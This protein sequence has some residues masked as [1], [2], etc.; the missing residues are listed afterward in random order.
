MICPFLSATRHGI[1]DPRTRFR[2]NLKARPPGPVKGERMRKPKKFFW[3]GPR[4]RRGLSRLSPEKIFRR[5][6]TGPGGCATLSRGN[7]PGSQ[8]RGGWPATGPI[9]APGSVLIPTPR[10]PAICP[11][12]PLTS[13]ISF[14]LRRG[15]T[16]KSLTNVAT[17]CY[18][19]PDNKKTVPPLEFRPL[20]K[21]ESR[22]DRYLSHAVTFTV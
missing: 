11:I 18:T 9:D 14:R 15:L 19:A 3:T 17:L 10:R 22:P 8:F 2:G 4:F 12:K 20:H 5:P 13:P 7:R 1:R 16:K 6:L 21:R